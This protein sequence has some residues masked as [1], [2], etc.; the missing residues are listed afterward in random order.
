M[1]IFNTK[2]KLTPE[3]GLSAIR[4]IMKFDEPAPGAKPEV[5]PEVKPTEQPSST[6]ILGRLDLLTQA[7]LKLVQK[8]DTVS[9]TQE[10]MKQQ[11]S[12]KF[13]VEKPKPVEPWPVELERKKHDRA[14]EK[15]AVGMTVFLANK[16]KKEQDFREKASKRLKELQAEYP[17]NP[18]AVNAAMMR[19]FIFQQ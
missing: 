19:E 14:L 8:L 12:A 16:A 9:Q 18:E 15:S 1:G 13:Q 4:Q 11:M 6:E 2:K 7:V 5:K 10:Q 3:E 17:S